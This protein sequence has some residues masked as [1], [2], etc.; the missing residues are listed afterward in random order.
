MHRFA[1]FSSRG[2]EA[3]GVVVMHVVG[4]WHETHEGYLVTISIGIMRLELRDV[5]WIC[6]LGMGQAFSAEQRI[7]ARRNKPGWKYSG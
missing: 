6:D 1:S 3:V 2:V 4:C 5:Q 7:A